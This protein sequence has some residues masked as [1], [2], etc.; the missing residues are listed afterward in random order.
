MAKEQVGFNVEIIDSY[1]LSFTITEL[2]E[3]GL[4]LADEDLDAQQ[5]ATIL[6]EEAKHSKNLILL[7]SL[8]QLQKGGRMSGA[9]FLVGNFLKIKPIFPLTQTVN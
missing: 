1:S 8:E 7:G 3:K 6:R 2:L 5:I 4:E 9:A